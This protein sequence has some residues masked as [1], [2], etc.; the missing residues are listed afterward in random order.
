[1]KIDANTTNMRVCLKS[2][3][4]MAAEITCPSSSESTLPAIEL[5]RNSPEICRYWYSFA[6]TPTPTPTP[7][8]DTITTDTLTVTNGH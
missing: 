7:T 5:R 4:T 2:I 6:T 8:T 3:V 1:M